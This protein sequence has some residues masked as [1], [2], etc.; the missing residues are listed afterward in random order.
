MLADT[1]EAP[2]PLSVDQI[3]E[4][5]RQKLQTL[6]DVLAE[7]A[8]QERQSKQWSQRTL[9][10]AAIAARRDAIDVY[11]DV[12]ERRKS[13]Q[14]A[15]LYQPDRW[16]GVGLVLFAFGLLVYIIDALG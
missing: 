13:L 15:L 8:Q 11:I 12:F 2:E 6:N 5:E 1:M 10:E 4:Q 9:Q 14:E 7:R 3:L 16:L